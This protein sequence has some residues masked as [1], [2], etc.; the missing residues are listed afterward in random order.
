MP[1][2]IP[3][4][5]CQNCRLEYV[6]KADHF[7]EKTT[8]DGEKYLHHLCKK[9]ERELELSQQSAEQEALQRQVQVAGFVQARVGYSFAHPQ[10]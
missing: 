9:C 10:L 8:S 4:K 7:T 5:T 2:R 6:A 1:P 3:R